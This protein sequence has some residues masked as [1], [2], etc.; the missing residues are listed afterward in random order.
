MMYGLG[1]K[2]S[3]LLEFARRK[4]TDE[5]TIFIDGFHPACNFKY[6]WETIMHTLGC[7][8]SQSWT[9]DTFRSCFA[10]DSPSR[11][12][13]LVINNIDGIN[14]RSEKIQTTLSILASTPNIHMVATI[15]HIHTVFMWDALKTTRFN[16]CWH[17][18]PTF[19][20]YLHESSYETSLIAT[21]DTLR[22]IRHVLKSL[23]S[24][25]QGIF[26]ILAEHQQDATGLAHG[27][28]F[29]KCREA[30]L[31]NSEVAFRTLLTEFLD[32]HI[33]TKRRLGGTDYYAIP[34]DTHSIS[35]LLETFEI[36]DED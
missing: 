29:E 13:Y 9:D 2:R 12:L 25:A 10:Q 17:A 4:L 18:T 21:T 20:P 15:D 35:M 30:F 11:R 24:N 32:H 36:I 23:T 34:L 19:E 26:R 6:I 31:I 7:S 16:W 14:L 1:S 5:T 27:L 8:S 28:L 3:L 22:G 33:F